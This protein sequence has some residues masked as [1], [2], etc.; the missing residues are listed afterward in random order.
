MKRPFSMP[1]TALLLTLAATA[2]AGCTP[3]TT[4]Q[5][6]DELRV[7]NVN[8][9]K[10]LDDARAAADVLQSNSA[11]L[12]NQVKALKSENADLRNQL[13]GASK[14][15]AAPA[16]ANG[17]EGVSGVETESDGKSVTVRIQGDVL[18]A[19]GKVDLKDSSLKTLDEVA[20]VLADK[21][22]GHAVRVAGFT[23]T[24]PIARSGWKDNLQLSCERS[25]AVVRELKKKGVPATTIYAAGYGDTQPRETKPKSRRVE[26][27]VELR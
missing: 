3:L 4:V 13:A 23:D 27:V 24:D 6:R 18:F 11:E 16:N 15:P 14:V 17:F 22:A 7:Q 19:A 8:L 9:H 12:Q 1:V 25:C 2:F 26:I 10:S 20:K 21:Y 5:E